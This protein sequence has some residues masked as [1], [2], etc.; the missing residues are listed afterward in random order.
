MVAKTIPEQDNAA[1]RA[2]LEQITRGWEALPEPAMIELRCLFPDR[3][4]DIM[5]F[6]PDQAGIDWLLDHAAAMNRTGLNTY[7]VVNP[8]KASA[9]IRRDGR[10]SGAFD[11]D[12]IAA[13]H[14]W[15]DA[16]TAEAADNIRAFVGPRYSFAV[17]TGTQPF[18]RPHIYW[19]LDE[20]C[21]D[22]S[23]WNETQRAI[24]ATLSTD[25]AVVNP[26]RIMR[27]PGMVN[28]PTD[29]KAAKGYVAE[30]STYRDKYPEP[31]PPISFETM[32]RAFKPAAPLLSQMAAAPGPG[33]FHIDTGTAPQ[34]LD[35]AAVTSQI[36]NGMDWHNNMVRLV[37]SYVA[38][39]LEDHEIHALTQPL[40]LPGWTGE[41]TAREVQT[42]IDGARRKGWTPQAASQASYTPNF[43]HAPAPTPSDPAPQAQ[44]WLVQS[45]A[46]FTADFVAP[47]YIIDGIIQRGRLYTLTAP[48]GSGKTA[49]MLYASTAISTGAAFCEKEVEPGDVLFLA[50]ENP[51]D[52]RA[53]TIATMEFYRIDPASC[54]LHFIPGTFSIRADIAKLEEEAAKLP[55]LILVVVDTFAAYFDGDDENSNAQALD[56]ARVMRRLTAFPTKPAV[57]MP[58]HP[59]KN[60]TRGNLSPKGGSSL[61][62]EVDGNL[63]LWNEG[64]MLSLHWQGKFRGAEFEP[65]AFELQRHESLKLLDRKGRSIPT[66]LAKPL[67]QMRAMQIA[68]ENLKIEDKLLISV[69]YNPEIPLAQRGVDVGLNHKQKVVRMLEKLEGQKLIKRFRTNWELTAEGKRAVDI[70]ESGGRFAPEI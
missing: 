19:R 37:G 2:Y 33:G 59:V 34:S 56:F 38:R 43:D 23:A 61:L 16:D 68:T 31:R 53:R 22:L 48:T 45:A 14:C 6:S 50:G 60:A 51:D 13:L 46:A 41:Q 54:R 24:A 4:P 70:L 20:P 44:G 67:L 18:P 8:V 7:V 12:I 64:G 57:I 40:T 10:N 17:L 62:N 1:A 66:I 63:T 36:A 15:A 42:A 28:W 69:K 3:T 49:V 32:Q 27:L 29:K 52:V 21:F 39:G 47:E 26:S 9:P 5:R 30:V 11:T 25:R 55:N 65:L 58:A 35:R